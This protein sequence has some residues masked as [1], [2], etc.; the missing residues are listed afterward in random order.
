ML[1]PSTERGGDHRW[2]TH[3][4]LVVEFC[5]SSCRNLANGDTGLGAGRVMLSI[6]EEKGQ[7]MSL[8]LLNVI[9]LV[10]ACGHIKYVAV[11]LDD[12]VVVEVRLTLVSVEFRLWLDSMLT[13]SSE[14][15]H[16]SAGAVDDYTY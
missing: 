3:L 13:S 5:L 4:G 7:H 14:N 10:E 2:N 6:T 1:R 16:R 11:P 15:E 8:V 9:S 12:L